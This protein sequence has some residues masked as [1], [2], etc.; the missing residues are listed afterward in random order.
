M[1]KAKAGKPS[2]GRKP[3]DEGLPYK[4]A[5]SV[6]GGPLVEQPKGGKGEGFEV[7]GSKKVQ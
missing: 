5:E 7:K 6:C 1:A 4:S 3:G 2:A